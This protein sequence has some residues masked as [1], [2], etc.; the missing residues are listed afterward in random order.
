MTASTTVNPDG[1]S[2]VK[3]INFENDD[4]YNQFMKDIAYWVSQDMTFND[5]LSEDIAY[6][7]ASRH[8]SKLANA[9]FRRVIKELNDEQEENI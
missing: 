9:V 2:M 3:T 4:E 5:E 7:I 8:M 6:E 1:S